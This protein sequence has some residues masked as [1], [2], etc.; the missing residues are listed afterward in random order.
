VPSATELLLAKN[1]NNLPA[2][3]PSVAEKKAKISLLA[4]NG[5]ESA[6]L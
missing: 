1:K 4:T 6:K 2:N 5:A 3:S